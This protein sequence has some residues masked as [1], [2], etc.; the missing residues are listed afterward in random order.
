M[1]SFC[2][3]LPWKKYGVVRLYNDIPGSCN[4]TRG[5]KQK[6]VKKVFSEEEM[7][8]HYGLTFLVYFNDRKSPPLYGVL[9]YQNR[10]E[11][12]YCMAMPDGKF[13]VFK[14]RAVD[15]YKRNIVHEV[16]YPLRECI[17][18][19]PELKIKR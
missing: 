6:V 10:K 8:Q 18:Q 16:C 11:N 5:I 17:R 4:S 15:Q 14:D 7:R 1:L 12:K 19:E 3:L 13:A 9:Y 2:F